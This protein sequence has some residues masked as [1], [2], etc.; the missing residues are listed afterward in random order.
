MVAK[1]R[2]ELEELE[3]ELAQ[4]NN[5]QRIEAELGDLLFAVVN[6]ARHAQVNPEQALRRTNHTFQQRFMAIEANLAARGLQP[7]QLSL[8]ELELEW[9]RVKKT[10][11]QSG[12]IKLSE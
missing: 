7:Q 6:L 4:Q 11:A 2:E 12:E 8:A 9:Q 5:Q 10:A 1:I 3:V